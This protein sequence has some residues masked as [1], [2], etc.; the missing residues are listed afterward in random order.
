[1][2]T[3]LAKH[4]LAELNDCKSLAE[5]ANIDRSDMNVSL[6]VW[7]RPCTAVVVCSLVDNGRTLAN[8]IMITLREDRIHPSLTL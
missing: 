2:Q 8:R 3:L 7:S 4:G 6:R 5:V 1:M